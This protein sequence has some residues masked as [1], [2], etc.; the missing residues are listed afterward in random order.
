MELF[1]AIPLA[2]WQDTKATL[3]RFTQIVG[4]IRLAAG[5]RRNHWWHVPFHLT[6]RGIT[7]RPT[8]RADGGPIFTVD[9]DLVGHRLVVSSLD[10]REVAFPLQGQSVASFYRE[11]LRALELLGV[12][13]EPDLPQTVQA[14]R[15]L[16][17]DI[18]REIQHLPGQA[19]QAL[20]EPVNIAAVFHE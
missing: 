4:K 3:H 5:I 9:F 14:H 1:P 12:T 15:L 18:G 7:T 19:A 16:W 11:T 8:G 10:G 6:G 20:G 2:E 17:V 13:A